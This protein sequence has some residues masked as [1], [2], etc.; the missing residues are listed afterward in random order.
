MSL[1]VFNCIILK[2]TGTDVMRKRSILLV[3]MV[4]LGVSLSGYLYVE[5]LHLGDVISEKST[6]IYWLEDNISG[7][8]AQIS[9]L[10]AR[11][12]T[13]PG[14]LKRSHALQWTKSISCTMRS[15]ALRA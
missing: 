15:V 6:R 14:G 8:S 5:N 7:L 9:W 1:S 3:V 11:A 4:L 12:S 10:E 2:K 13:S